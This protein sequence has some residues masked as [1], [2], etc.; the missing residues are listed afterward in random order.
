MKS[1]GTYYFFNNKTL[2]PINYNNFT[3]EILLD[4]MSGPHMV[5]WTGIIINNHVFFAFALYIYYK[6]TT[7]YSGKGTFI[8][9]T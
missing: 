5:V 4:A 8:F 9:K 2:H 3:R 6:I 7:C 1:V